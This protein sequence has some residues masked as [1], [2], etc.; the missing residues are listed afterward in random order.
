MFC[1]DIRLL[2]LLFNLSGSLVVQTRKKDISFGV[3]DLIGGALV[4]LFK[5][6]NL[7]DN[8]LIKD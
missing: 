4:K 5:K 1:S 8:M 3:G 6:R 7:I 2:F